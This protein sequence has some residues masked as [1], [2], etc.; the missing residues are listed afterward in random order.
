MTRYLVMATAAA[1]IALIA[2]PAMAADVPT[3]D[4][5]GSRVEEAGEALQVELPYIRMFREPLH[6]WKIQMQ[7]LVYPN[8]RFPGRLWCD[9]KGKLVNVLVQLP[10]SI[11]TNP[12]INLDKVSAVLSALIYGYSGSHDADKIIELAYGVASARLGEV[13]GQD[14]PAV[15]IDK[16]AKI[17]VITPVRIMLR[18]RPNCNAHEELPYDDGTDTTFDTV[19]PFCLSDN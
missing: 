15:S 4:T 8:I 10:W 9:E 17:A 11:A 2:V 13:S 5:F 3:C 6:Q 14:V 1:A 16:D 18:A 7:D 19:K 12:S